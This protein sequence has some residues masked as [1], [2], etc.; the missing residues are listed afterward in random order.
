MTIQQTA[1]YSNVP[2]YIS[3]YYYADKSFTAKT[4]SVAADRYTLTTPN[5]IGSDI[6]GTSLDLIG[7]VNIDLSI[8][9]NWDSQTPTDYT[10]AANRAGKDFYVYG[11]WPSGNNALKL[12]VSPNATYPS[13][14]TA[15]NSRKIGG[16]HC[17]CADVGATVPSTHPA[18]GY[19]AGDIVPTS[20]WDLK[21][22]CSSMS[23][24]G[25]HYDSAS[26]LWDFIYMASNVGGKPASVFGGTIWNSINWMDA[27]D[28]VRLAKM[29]L[30]QDA[31]FQSVA[32]G[33]NEETNIYGSADPVTT[34]GHVD[35]TGRRMISATFAEDCCGVVWHW[36][37]DG[38]FRYDSLPFAWLDPGGGKGKLYLEGYDV[39][40][41]AGGWDSGGGI[42]G[43]RCRIGDFSRWTAY[44]GIGFRLVARGVN[45]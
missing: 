6:G 41:S 34:G 29:R 16:F 27:Y 42:C 1:I 24:A 43:S 21:F 7:S 32:Y 39:K 13:G 23:N 12:L 44:S 38:S 15:S 40:L 3:Q 18:Y 22:R 4:V 25:L 9:A 19:L 28:V 2:K 11:V 10:V 30:P 45:R 37:A 20:V 35:T 5:F 36:L 33:S 26:Q 14:Y 31:E 8:G 17:L